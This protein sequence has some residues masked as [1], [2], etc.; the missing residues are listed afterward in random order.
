MKLL[1]PIDILTTTAEA[2][3]H[4][5][6]GGNGAGVDMQGSLN[7]PLLSSSLRHHPHTPTKILPK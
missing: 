1:Y 3:E 6:L 4:L 5:Q 7:R 2:E